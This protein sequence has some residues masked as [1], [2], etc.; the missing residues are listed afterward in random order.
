MNLI[1]RLASL[2]WAVIVTT[3]L[4]L[5]ALVATLL[6]VLMIAM[7]I[8]ILVMLWKKT[9]GEWVLTGLLLIGTIVLVDLLTTP[10]VRFGLRIAPLPVGRPKGGRLPGTLAISWVL[11]LAVLVSNDTEWQSLFAICLAG[12]V[13]AW[14][15]RSFKRAWTGMP[16][17]RF[18]LFLR[19]FGK[20]GDRLVG[21]AIRHAA[22]E[23]AALAFLVGKRNTGES[24]DPFLVGFDGLGSGSDASSVP[25][26]L[27][28]DDREWIDRVRD[29][30]VRA[31]AVVFDAT[32]WSPAMDIEAKLL[33]ESDV[34]AKTIV[35]ARKGK[36]GPETGVPRRSAIAY[37]R[38]WRA[39]SN[40][41]VLG[42]VATV[43]LPLVIHAAAVSRQ[44]PE[45]VLAIPCVA[46]W[47][48]LF[49]RPLMDKQSAAALKA[50][51]WE[52]FK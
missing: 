37:S 38:S 18:V 45:P 22:P 40:R 48:W 27:E 29:L 13:A 31:D 4:W 17:E 50:E 39:A 21:S 20:S 30:V 49:V 32:D 12:P 23:K 5:M 16:R 8:G 44:D 10:V 47:V 2:I 52:I 9:V 33:Q 14:R 19:R 1:G 7:P 11:A 3:L 43:L 36:A 15:L 6:P 34:A 28:A 42:F 41:I 26:Y 46:L 25:L 51:L 35:L 24:W